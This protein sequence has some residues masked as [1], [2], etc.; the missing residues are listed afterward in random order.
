MQRN[1]Y[2]TGAY[3][4]AEDFKKLHQTLEEYESKAKSGNR[5]FYLSL[6]PFVFDVATTHIRH[7]CWGQKYKRICFSSTHI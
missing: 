4:R 2:V 7:D 1:I 3:D 5:V 6:P